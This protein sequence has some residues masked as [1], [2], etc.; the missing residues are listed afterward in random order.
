MSKLIYLESDEEIT[1]VIDKISKAEEKSVSLVISRGSTLANSVVNLKLLSKR[2]GALGKNV[3]LVTNDKIAK[4]LASQIGIEVF[5]NISAAKAGARAEEPIEPVA[6]EVPTSPPGETTKVDGVLV[7]QYDRGGEEVGETPEPPTEAIEPEAPEIIEAVK[8]VDGSSAE[9]SLPATPKEAPIAETPATNNYKLIKKPLPS[10]DH[11][12]SEGSP[13]NKIRFGKKRRKIIIGSIIAGA[14]VIILLTLYAVLPKATAKISVT[15][16][17][18]SLS[19]DFSVNRDAVGVDKDNKIIPGKYISKEEELEKPFAASGQKNIGEKAKGKITV[20]NYWNDEPQNVPA[21]SR[22]IT[23]TGVAF[24]ST[25]TVT[26]PA[27]HAIIIPPSTYKIDPP[28]TVDVNVEAADVGDQGNI[29]PSD[30][31]ITSIPKVQ[32]SKIYG[33]SSAAMTSGSNNIVKIVADKDL[34]EAKESTEKELKAKIT[35]EIKAGLAENEQ[36]LDQAIGENISAE[37]S[38][39]KAGDQVDAFFYKIKIKIEAITFSEDD[40]KIL[41]LDNAKNQLPQDKEIVSNADEKIKY[42]VAN[43]DLGKGTIALKGTFDGYIAAKYDISAIKKEIKGRSI[44]TATNKITAH[45][46][47]LSVDI[48]TW[49]G[50]LRSLPLIERR[51]NIEFNYGSQ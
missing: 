7:H 41:L 47:V 49:P 48:T 16:E 5:N 30:F 27:G 3:S 36:L 31:T 34:K 18:F 28:G 19:A 26:V 35:D 45:T 17:P 6:K 43:F 10:H 51:I 21:G 44:K 9:D 22:F 8:D 39:D 13:F 25:S 14:V 40:A 2:G 33:K 46:G 50:F 38:S 4:N 1:D 15:S 24:I 42:E 20:Y 12:P 37:S 11:Q 32:Q 23:S 29:G